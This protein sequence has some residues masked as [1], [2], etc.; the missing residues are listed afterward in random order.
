MTGPSQR[1][2]RRAT[3]IVV[4]AGIVAL[5]VLAVIAKDQLSVPTSPTEPAAAVE[6]PQVTLDRALVANAP[7]LA[8]YHPLTCDPCVE[9]IMIAV[10]MYFVWIA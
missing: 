6:A 3:Q 9:V 10:G 8:F 5:V 7:T 1:S 4:V 2:P